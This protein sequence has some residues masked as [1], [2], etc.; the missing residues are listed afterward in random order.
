[1]PI[2]KR[3][4]MNIRLVDPTRMESQ[5]SPGSQLGRYLALRWDLPWFCGSDVVDSS[6]MLTLLA[7]PGKKGVISIAA[8]FW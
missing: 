4:L 8:S 7:F 5:S 6:A 3:P 2:S 1:M